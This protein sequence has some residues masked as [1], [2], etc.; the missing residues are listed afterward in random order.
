MTA[1]ERRKQSRDQALYEDALNTVR[2]LQA[3]TTRYINRD[4]LPF[5][6]RA[7]S[8]GQ[9]RLVAGQVAN[10]SMPTFAP[11][12]NIAAQALDEDGLMTGTIYVDVALDVVDTGERLAIIDSVGMRY[13]AGAWRVCTKKP[14]H[15][16]MKLTDVDK[17][18]FL[19]SDFSG[20]AIYPFLSAMPPSERHRLLMDIMRHV[21]EHL[22]D[23]ETTRK[24]FA[25]LGDSDLI[26]HGSEDEAEI[27]TPRRMAHERVRAWQEGREAKGQKSYN[28]RNELAS[29]DL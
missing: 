29:Q 17:E 14:G 22:V 9:L 3:S 21:D 27:A 1:R 8:R 25:R 4:A 10:V 15:E 16:H 23:P 28:Y 7:V 11:Y 20:D 18:G 2:Q 5:I 13:G 6:L 19:N 12:G 26:L 24:L